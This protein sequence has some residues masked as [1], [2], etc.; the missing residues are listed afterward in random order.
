MAIP[1]AK[2]GGELVLD[3]E[4]CVRLVS[5]A[6][7]PCAFNVELRLGWCIVPLDHPLAPAE[8]ER[9][10]AWCA[11]VDNG[12]AS[13]AVA[14]GE[15]SG[16]VRLVIALRLAAAGC[17]S[18]RLPPEQQQVGS[19]GAIHP[20]VPLPA[21]SS[22]LSRSAS[23][24]ENPNEMQVVVPPSPSLYPSPSPPPSRS[25]RSSSPSPPSPS[26]IL[27]LSVNE[28]EVG[29]AG[30]APLVDLAPWPSVPSGMAEVHWLHPMLFLTFVTRSPAVLYVLGVADGSTRQ[31]DLPDMPLK[32]VAAAHAPVMVVHLASDVVLVVAVVHGTPRRVLA[33]VPMRAADSSCVLASDGRLAAVWYTP[34]TAASHLAV[35]AVENGECLARLDAEGWSRELPWCV[36]PLLVANVGDVHLADDVAWLVLHRADGSLVAVD[37]VTRRVIELVSNSV[38]CVDL[39]AFANGGVHVVWAETSGR[40]AV[41]RVASDVMAASVCSTV[42]DNF[43]ASVPGASLSL[44]RLCDDGSS[45][46]VLAANA[47][48]AVVCV[49]EAA[50]EPTLRILQ[51]CSPAASLGP[52]TWTMT[53]LSETRMIRVS[54]VGR[55][56]GRIWE[57]ASALALARPRV[58]G[59][60]TP[61]GSSLLAVAAVKNRI[62]VAVQEPEPRAQSNTLGGGLLVFEPVIVDALHLSGQS[63][64]IASTALVAPVNRSGR[65]ALAPINA[66]W[67]P[68]AAERA[69]LWLGVFDDVVALF[70]HP[71]LPGAR[72]VVEE[73]IGTW[74]HGLLQAFE[75]DVLPD[76][77]VAACTMGVIWTAPGCGLNVAPVP[78]GRLLL[79]PR[80][81]DPSTIVTLDLAHAAVVLYTVEAGTLSRR[82]VISLDV[83]MADGII[84]GRMRDD[85]LLVTV[86]HRSG[87]LVFSLDV[88]HARQMRLQFLRLLS[89]MAIGSIFV[90]YEPTSGVPVGLGPALAAA[91]ELL[92]AI[93]SVRRVSAVYNVLAV[94]STGEWACVWTRDAVAVYALGSSSGLVFPC[95]MWTG[96]VLAGGVDEAVEAPR[97]SVSIA[98]GKAATGFVLQ[99]LGVA[100]TIL[101]WTGD[102]LSV[103]HELAGS[104]VRVYAAG[105]DDGRLW[106]T[107]L[108]LRSDSNPAVIESRPLVGSRNVKVVCSLET[109]RVL[110]GEAVCA[111]ADGCGCVVAT[112]ADDAETGSLVLSWIDPVWMGI[113]RAI[114]SSRLTP[115]MCESVDYVRVVSLAA[116]AGSKPPVAL[117]EADPCVV[118]PMGGTASA[119]AGLGP[120]DLALLTPSGDTVPML[121]SSLLDHVTEV[122][123]N[124]KVVTKTVEGPTVEHTWAEIGHRSKALANVLRHELGLG[125]SDVAG[126]LAWNT[127]RHLELY[128]AVSGSGLINHT[129]N[130]RLHP[131]QV[132]YI[133]NHAEDKALFVDSTF[134]PLV[135]AVA[136]RLPSSLKAVVALT[137]VD[138]MPAPDSDVVR[139]LGDVPLLCYEDMVGAAST[140]FEWPVFDERRAAA[141]CYTSGT[142]GN[143]KGVLYSHR[144]TMLHAYG[145]CAADSL[146]LSSRDTAMLIVPLFHV[147]AWGIPYAAQ[148]CGSSLVLPGPNLDGQSV[149]ELMRDYKVNVSFGVPSVWTMF[150]QYLAEH[151]EIAPAEALE[152]KRVIIGGSAAPRA[153]IEAFR[154][155]LDTF[156]VH[157]WGMTETSPLGVI[158]NPLPKHDDLS[159]DEML[160]QVQS[161]QGRRMFG[162]DV[163]VTDEN[164]EQVPHDGKTP[165][166]IKVR[167]PWVASA[168]YKRDGE[169]A[170][171]FAADGWMTTGDVATMNEDG[172]VNIT[173]RMKDM[174]NGASLVKSGGE[175]ISSIELENAAMGH[176]DVSEVAVI[177]VKHS[178]WEE[179]PLM[180]AIRSPAAVKAGKSDE[181]IKANIAKH[182]TTKVAKWQIPDDVVFVDALPYTATGKVLKRQLRD[183]LGDYILPTDP[184]HPDYNSSN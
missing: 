36:S 141:L 101:V 46:Y 178:K 138:H 170:D 174:I 129:L 100:T 73:R 161:K 168:Y 74:R 21:A 147:N 120:A 59:W 50:P 55:V 173:D 19:A 91:N 146:A 117:I 6:K 128:M 61:V 114:G 18:S 124:V 51:L 136:D 47:A 102:Q 77:S 180:V 1:V 25:S 155:Q 167:G 62:S 88:A 123:P 164:D 152:L 126:T 33:D 113:G 87:P 32:V 183:D 172:Y 8:A 166:M 13:V 54:A 112:G 84:C 53:W 86:C 159:P 45:Y 80:V 119:L 176:P 63:R 144:S 57:V 38:A 89:G 70:A 24:A 99:Q 93:P 150:F 131:D 66:K 2:L 30:A 15:G 11:A 149:F 98:V 7:A 64:A 94:E 78:E 22:S 34:S 69:K 42:L 105:H 16:P 3:A 104:R 14:D 49:Y 175:W 153:M 96:Q 182:M 48:M 83:T 67:H 12:S 148:M 118:V 125:G 31:L 39:A 110:A 133:M 169:D 82:A 106:M 79:R 76:E 158:S 27:P 162:I 184:E 90:P 10:P 43:D 157:A 132:A 121:I 156:V 135:A 140:E 58:L 139:A 142:T 116:G 97:F 122:H 9:W 72:V 41:A 127:H 44:H 71:P 108:D 29:D 171:T 92:P 23:S 130:P 81:I 85:E 163:K 17:C 179:R 35:Y 154:D 165:G 65:V 52:W 26:P 75:L 181:E 56:S 134:L 143:P 151:P 68:L 137:D 145:A 111:R 60:R 177:G 37:I 28:G 95:G 107:A 4:R 20:I 40:L 115:G 5:K 103:G 160:D 109:G